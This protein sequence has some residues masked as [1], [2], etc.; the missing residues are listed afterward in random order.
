MERLNRLESWQRR[1][2]SDSKGQEEVEQL[3][4]E[5][6]EVKEDASSREKQNLRMTETID[7]QNRQIIKIMQQ[8][9]S[10]VQSGGQILSSKPSTPFPSGT[11]DFPD[12]LE[13]KLMTDLRGKITSESTLVLDWMVMEN[14]YFQVDFLTKEASFKLCDHFLRKW[15]TYTDPKNEKA[16]DMEDMKHQSIIIYIILDKLKKLKDGSKKLYSENHKKTEILKH[17]RFLIAFG[18]NI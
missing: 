8:L 6:E 18:V 10:G 9:E 7:N 16:F 13:F 1:K 3:K 14:L 15:V 5:L 12:W 4:R 2:T 17:L 11:H